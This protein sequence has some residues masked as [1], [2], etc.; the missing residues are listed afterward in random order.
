[1]KM[2][3]DH[4]YGKASGVQVSVKDARVVFVD[5][6]AVTMRSSLLSKQDVC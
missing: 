2:T 5:E 6:N 4:G 3:F 1:M